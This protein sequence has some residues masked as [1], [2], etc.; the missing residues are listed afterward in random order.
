M[1]LLGVGK[2]IRPVKKPVLDCKKV[3]PAIAKGPE[4]HTACKKKLDVGLLVV[5]I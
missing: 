1:L 3:A 4:G 5:M 2:G